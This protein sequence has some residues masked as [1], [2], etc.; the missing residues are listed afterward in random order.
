MIRKK[1]INYFQIGFK[2]SFLGIGCDGVIDH[3]ESSY[4]FRSPGSL[5]QGPEL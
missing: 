1:E 4:A 2:G 3:G 5:W